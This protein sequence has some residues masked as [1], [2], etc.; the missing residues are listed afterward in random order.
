[1]EWREMPMPT[2]EVLLYLKL[3]FVLVGEHF[4]GVIPAGSWPCLPGLVLSSQGSSGQRWA[5]VLCVGHHCCEIYRSVDPWPRSARYHPIIMAP[6]P[7]GIR[8]LASF[9][10]DQWWVLYVC[11]SVRSI[12]SVGLSVQVWL[13]RELS[14]KLLMTYDEKTSGLKPYCSCV[15]LCRSVHVSVSVL[16]AVFYLVLIM[17]FLQESE[18]AGTQRKRART[19]QITELSSKFPYIM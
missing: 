14:C 6:V 19:L 10:R 12:C 13:T 8:F 1:M 2:S 17:Y 9:N 11:L 18:L 4:W 15:C 3:S 7:P 5:A 16:V